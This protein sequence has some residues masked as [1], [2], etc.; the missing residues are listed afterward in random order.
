MNNQNEALK[1][2]GEDYETKGRFCSYWHQ[3][4]EVR[5]AIPN[6][7]AGKKVLIIGKGSGI[8][9]GFLSR[10]GYC[11]ETLDIDQSLNP[12]HC[13]S[14]LDMPMLNGGVRYCVMLSSFRAFTI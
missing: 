8:V 1:Y 7:E 5:K 6:P 14:V 10:L 9:D 3:V 11:V 2:S 13:A 4:D 12:T